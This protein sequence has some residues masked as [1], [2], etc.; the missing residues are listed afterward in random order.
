MADGDQTF[1]VTTDTRARVHRAKSEYVWEIVCTATYDSDDSSAVTVAIPLNGIIRNIV[2][3]TPNTANDDLTSTL[4]IR[5]NSDY[6]I[7]TTGSG[8]AETTTNSYAVDLAVSGNI[9]LVHTLNEAA[10]AAAVFT[11]T[12][13]GV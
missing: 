4:L 13:R 5:D 9:D 1:V 7:F 10:G 2:Y 12:L 3:V 6:T 8:I 11:V